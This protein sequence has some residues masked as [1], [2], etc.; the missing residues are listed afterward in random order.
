MSDMREPSSVR[1]SGRLRRTPV[2]AFVMRP[3]FVAGFEPARNHGR[4]T[5]PPWG[6]PLLARGY[7]QYRPVGNDRGKR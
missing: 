1:I 7:L 6:A 5:F 4:V 3:L 2:H